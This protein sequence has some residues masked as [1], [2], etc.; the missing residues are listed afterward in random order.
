MGGVGAGP[1]G[2]GAGG[3]GDIRENS[4]LGAREVGHEFGVE[5][6]VRVGGREVRD[7]GEEPVQQRHHQTHDR[8]GGGEAGLVAWGG[9]GG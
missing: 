4:C 9:T 8:Q 6:A 5:L 3:G 2:Q 1:C 7:V